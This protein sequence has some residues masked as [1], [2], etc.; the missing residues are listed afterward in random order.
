[1]SKKKIKLTQGLELAFDAY[2]IK[3]KD[4]VRHAT[5]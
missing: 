3:F 1:M 4:E 2:S 5:P